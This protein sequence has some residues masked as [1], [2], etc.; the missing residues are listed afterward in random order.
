V[1]HVGQ[2]AHV[3]EHVAAKRIRDC[4]GF[5]EGELVAE[6]DAEGAVLVLRDG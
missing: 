6:L 2:L 3:S 1:T 5:T 4:P